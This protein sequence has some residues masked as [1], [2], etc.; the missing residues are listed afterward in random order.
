MARWTLCAHRG[1][2]ARAPENTLPAFELAL[3]VAEEIELDLWASRDGELFVCHD[4]TVDRTTN[5]HG[6]IGDLTSDEIK[7]LDAGAWFS[8]DFAGVRLPTF[9]ETLA[10][11]G[12]R[13]TLNIHIKSPVRMDAQS[14][15]MRARRKEYGDFYRRRVVLSSLPP[16]G[17]TIDE[18]ET[19]AVVPYDESVFSRILA[20]LD[21]FGCRDKAYITGDADVMLTSR[22]LAPSLPRCCLEGDSNY[23]LVENAVKYGCARLQ[24][25]KMY[26]SPDMLLSAREHGLRC[27]LFW[28]DDPEEAKWLLS[29]GVD[30]LLTN[31]CAAM[32]SSL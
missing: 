8:P 10:L 16:R 19:R 20:S 3:G 14:D 4:R 15:A 9:D 25:C 29:V 31:D 30:T 5:G 7:L 26:T 13:A 17:E 27:N 28:S 21:R 2:N 1:L 11:V 12:G 24:F 32:R 23:T 22:K 6:A 18:V